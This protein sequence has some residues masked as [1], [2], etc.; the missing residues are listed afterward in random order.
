MEGKSAWQCKEGVLEKSV[1]NLVRKVLS[2][3]SY[4]TKQWINMAKRR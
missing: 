4:P 3:T 2:S 1:G